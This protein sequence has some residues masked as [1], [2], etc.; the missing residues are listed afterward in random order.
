M[1]VK[2]EV[3]ESTNVC[4]IVKSEGSES[5]NMYTIVKLEGSESTNMCTIVKSEVP[6]S[7]NVRTIVKSEGSESTNVRTIVKQALRYIP[8]FNN[9]SDNLTAPEVQNSINKNI[10][11]TL[12][13]YKICTDM[14]I[15]L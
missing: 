10:R 7:T 8:V 2:S 1:I 13:E 3:P 5:T 9:L 12:H 11:H 6:E 4:T 15:L 14:I